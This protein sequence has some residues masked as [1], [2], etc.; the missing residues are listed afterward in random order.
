MAVNEPR[1]PVVL[2]KVAVM[3]SVL[4]SKAAKSEPTNQRR[5][6]L[7]SSA[8]LLASYRESGR[9][10]PGSDKMMLVSVKAGSDLSCP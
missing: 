2:T 7:P 3:V 4:A 5:D 8:S 9:T 1:P 10:T 6:N